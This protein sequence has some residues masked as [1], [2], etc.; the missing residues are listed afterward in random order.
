MIASLGEE[1]GD[2]LERLLAVGRAMDGNDVERLI[3]E[4]PGVEGTA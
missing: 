1:L 2:D 4:L 3:L